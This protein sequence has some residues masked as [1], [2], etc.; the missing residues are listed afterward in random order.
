[1]PDICSSRPRDPLCV[2]LWLNIACY[3]RIKFYAKLFSGRFGH[4]S[5]VQIETPPESNWL[6]FY[7]DLRHDALGPAK[8]W[9]QAAKACLVS[10]N[11]A[12]PEYSL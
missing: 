2:T 6:N 5:I 11:M 4:R 3:K 9:I 1:M 7:S 10:L 8:C 12:I